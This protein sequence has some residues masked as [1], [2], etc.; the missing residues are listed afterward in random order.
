MMM[1]FKKRYGLAGGMLFAVTIIFIIQMVGVRRDNARMVLHEDRFVLSTALMLD[2]KANHKLLYD[3]NPRTALVDIN[4]LKNRPFGIRIHKT[5]N[6]P[7]WVFSLDI[8]FVQINAGLSHFPGHPPE[9]NPLLAIRIWPGNQATLESHRHHARP[10]NIRLIFFRQRLVDSDREYRFVDD[11][12]FWQTFDFK[13]PD[14]FGAVELPLAF[15]DGIGP[16][17]EFPGQI[18]M[19][20]CRLE[21]LDYYAGA[22]NSSESEAVQASQRQDM[23]SI[24]EIEFIQ[25]RNYRPRV[26]AD[27]SCMRID[28][29]ACMQNE[30]N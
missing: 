4:H 13:L 29:R 21:I 7:D 24:S 17:S 30:L 19:I 23:V 25:K 12:I 8:P 5:T 16:S 11:P 9:P 15:T 20:W 18:D 26:Q 3:R 28:G 14:H 2:R 6:P 1:S 27:D 22:D 10:R